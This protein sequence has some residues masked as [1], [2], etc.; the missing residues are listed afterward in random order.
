MPFRGKGG[1][2]SWCTGEETGGR[3]VNLTSFRVAMK[4]NQ[5]ESLERNGLIKTLQTL[6]SKDSS[7]N[8]SIQLASVDVLNKLD[9]N[10]KNSENRLIVLQNSLHYLQILYKG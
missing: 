7:F 5:D 3:R 6:Y 9:Q 1:D 4:G 2:G 10:K 8:F